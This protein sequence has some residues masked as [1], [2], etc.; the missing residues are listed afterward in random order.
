M[1]TSDRSGRDEIWV[2]EVDGS[3]PVQLTSLSSPRWCGNPRWSPDGDRIL[4]SI[5]LEGLGLWNIWV[6]SSE[7]GA[8]RPLT[9]GQS[10]NQYANW[11]RDGERFYFTSNRGGQFD[12]WK[13]RLDGGDPVQVTTSGG[14]NAIESVDGEWLFY[15]KDHNP[16][17][18][19]SL[20][21]VPLRGGVEEKVLESVMRSYFVGEEGIFFISQT[22]PEH[23]RSTSPADAYLQLYRF[24]S[25]QSEVIAP[26]H[27][28]WKSQGLSVSPD[29]R[30]FLFTDAVQEGGDL[31]M[32]E[33][34]Q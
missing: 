20:W 10:I 21:R 8:A 33:D 17:W 6:V 26:V 15:I 32:L 11:S 30:S 14:A 5:G 31:V 1:F 29:G 4:F 22:H 16:A 24:E 7:G 27:T 13:V 34:F 25:R 3:N 12:V 23:G 9:S 19:T 2:S 28:A 18:E